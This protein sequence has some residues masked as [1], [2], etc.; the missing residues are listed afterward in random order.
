MIITK[1][2]TGINNQLLQEIALLCSD[3]MDIDLDDIFAEFFT[4]K[5]YIAGLASKYILELKIPIHFFFRNNGSEFYFARDII[6]TFAHELQ[7]IADRQNNLE[8][9]GFKKRW[10]KR[11][12][13]VRAEHTKNL[14]LERIDDTLPFHDITIRLAKEIRRIRKDKAE[15]D[16]DYK[17][18]LD[19]FNE[20]FKRMTKSQPEIYPLVEEMK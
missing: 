13:E 4:S 17:M 15:V 16:I 7:H 3:L 18:R 9:S 20:F 5:K 14:V 12:H 10:G 6:G 11:P 1:N 8:F 19:N 2:K